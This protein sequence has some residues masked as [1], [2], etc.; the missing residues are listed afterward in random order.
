MPHQGRSHVACDGAKACTCLCATGRRPLFAPPHN[1]PVRGVSSAERRER[2]NEGVILV[3]HNSSVGA[4]QPDIELRV[5]D[6]SE[7]VP[8]SEGPY[9]YMIVVRFI[10]VSARADF[11]SP[12]WHRL[13]SGDVFGVG[14][15]LTILIIMRCEAVPQ[16]FGLGGLGG[17]GGVGEVGERRG[18]EGE[19]TAFGGREGLGQRFASA[20]VRVRW[21]SATGSCV[22][23]ETIR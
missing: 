14:G 11:R 22:L 6:W 21:R 16:I 8:G 12:T 3:V 9:R 17:L 20:W 19:A 5:F 2:W 10:L 1:Q 7:V 18:R 23:R 4:L 13:G 15:A